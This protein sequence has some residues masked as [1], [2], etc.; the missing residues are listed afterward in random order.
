M[1]IVS[2]EELLKD[3][4]LQGSD[5]NQRNEAH[6]RALGETERRVYEA[7]EILPTGMEDLLEKTALSIPELSATLDSLMKK[8]LVK[9][10]FPGA[11][12]CCY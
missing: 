5:Q 7:L 2:V 12:R 11:Y 3:L 4:N 10:G 8:H 6:V 9:E 1:P